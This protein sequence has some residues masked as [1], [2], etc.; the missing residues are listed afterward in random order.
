[1]TDLSPHPLPALI[2]KISRSWRRHIDAALQPYGLTE[3]TWS[4]L[5]WIGRA[6]S[7]PSQSRLAA[8]MG[9]ERSAVV[10]LI[11]KLE[12]NGMVR[13]QPVAQDRRSWN[14]VL[15]D[16]GQDVARKVETVTAEIR[17]RVL[18]GIAAQDIA[19]TTGT[20]SVIAAALEK[21]R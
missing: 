2:G 3:A 17:E 11:D 14:L 19:V 9:L 10:R 13:R 12:D 18:Q 20:L 4:P 8:M 1:M 15:T 21:D 6:S 5:V 16:K 7:P